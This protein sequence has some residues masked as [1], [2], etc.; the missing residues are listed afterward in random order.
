M[1][2]MSEREVLTDLLFSEKKITNNY[3]IYSNEANNTNLRNELLGILNSEHDIHNKLYDAMSQ[4]GWYNPSNANP[5][6]IQ[7]SK[8]NFQNIKNQL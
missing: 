1:P 8:Q 2:N 6:D 3:D 7:K 4:K 5:Q